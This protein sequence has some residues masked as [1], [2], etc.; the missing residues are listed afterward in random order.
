MSRKDFCRGVSAVGGLV[1]PLSATGG[2]VSLDGELS[3]AGSDECGTEVEGMCGG[4]TFSSK[5]LT[6]LSLD[7]S[8]EDI[9]VTRLLASLLASTIDIS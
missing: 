6:G 8:V 2:G 4:M 1:Q 9:S 7:G 5:G 3:S